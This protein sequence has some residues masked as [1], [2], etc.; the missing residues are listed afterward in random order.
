MKDKLIIF[1]HIPKTG[2]TT[3]NEIF[4]KLYGQ[5]EIYDHIPI[6]RMEENFNQLK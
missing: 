4:A 5:N 2:G 1:M 3:L 6:E